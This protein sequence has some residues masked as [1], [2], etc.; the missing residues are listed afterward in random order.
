[1]GERVTRL[2][3]NPEDRGSMFL[4]NVGKLLPDYIAGHIRRKCS[5][6]NQFILCFLKLDI[7][8]MCTS[9]FRRG[10]KISFCGNVTN[11]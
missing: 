8:V 1:V 6:R 5:H 3:F 10:V 7:S 11:V 2:L 4:Q 9:G